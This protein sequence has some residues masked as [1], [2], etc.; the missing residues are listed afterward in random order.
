MNDLIPGIIMR[1]RWFDWRLCRGLPSV[2]HSGMNQTG[3]VFYF[4]SNI[5]IISCRDTPFKLII[6]S[7]RT[8]RL[9]HRYTRSTI[10]VFWI[11]GRV[12]FIMCGS[13][14]RRLICCTSQWR[15]K[16]MWFCM[17]YIGVRRKWSNRIASRL[18]STIMPISEIIYRSTSICCWGTLRC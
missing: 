6:L 15:Y 18:I 4:L 10:V 7:H 17:C 1:L 12:G 5:V 9:K 3:C 2:R 16:S 11:S 8:L 14:S 13:M